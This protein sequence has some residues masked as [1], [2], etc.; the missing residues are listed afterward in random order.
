MPRVI[1][2]VVLVLLGSRGFC[3]L[4]ERESHRLSLAIKKADLEHGETADL[5]LNLLRWKTAAELFKEKTFLLVD[6]AGF[7]VKLYHDDRLVL[8][9]RALVGSRKSPTP[10]FKTTIEAVVFNPYWNIPKEIAIKEMLP[11]IQ[12][13][14]S[15]LN[16]YEIEGSRGEDLRG[17]DWAR[18]NLFSFPHFLRQAP[19]PKNPLGRVKFISRNPYSVLLHDT[20]EPQLFDAVDRAVSH[21]CVRV[22]KAAQL[23]EL[24]TGIKA[25]EEGTERRIRLKE[26]L[27]VYFGYWTAWADENLVIHR[28][29]DVYEWDRS[30]FRIS[31]ST[32][33]DFG[34]PK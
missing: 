23:A 8:E 4:F 7:A 10:V 5:R 9:S 26:K 11:M 30:E 12:N 16:E 22:E 28:R 6:I 21:G 31:R 1:S 2:I 27:A 14:P 34:D 32:G 3:S 20:V 13:N 18:T 15:L 17:I 25:V 29:K 19:G 24:L 33:G